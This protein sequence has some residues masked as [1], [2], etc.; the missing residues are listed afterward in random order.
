M[1][2]RAFLALVIGALAALGTQVTSYGLVYPAADRGT[3]LPLV[4]ALVAGVLLAAF[5]ACLSLRA[6]RRATLASERFLALLGLVLSCFFLF[7]VVVGFGVPE[8]FV[9]TKD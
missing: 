4:L 5:A 1:R 7:V 8:I 9:G 3:K 2:G 6:H